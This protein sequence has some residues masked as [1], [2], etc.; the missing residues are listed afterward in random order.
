MDTRRPFSIDELVACSQSTD[1]DPSKSF[2]DLLKIVAAECDAGE[3]ARAANDLEIAFIHFTKASNLVLI[4][5]PTHPEY[6]WRTDRS[7]IVVF[8]QRIHDSLET[9]KPLV[10]ERFSDWRTRHPGADLSTPAPASEVLHQLAA[11]ATRHDLNKW[12]RDLVETATAEHNAGE[13]AKAT[14]DPESACIHFANASTLML[15]ELPTHPKFEELTQDQRA[16]VAMLG[17]RMLNSLGEAK[18]L[19][20]EQYS[21]RRIRRPGA[22]LPASA[23]ASA[24]FQPSRGPTAQQQQQQQPQLSPQDT[25]EGVQL[26]RWARQHQEAPRPVT[27]QEYPEHTLG[28]KQQDDTSAFAYDQVAKIVATRN[29]EKQEQEWQRKDRLEWEEIL[30][31]KNLAQEVAMNDETVTAFPTPASSH[32]RVR[33]EPYETH[34]P[35][36]NQDVSFQLQPHWRPLPRLPLRARRHEV[37]IQP[38][39]SETNLSLPAP[40]NFS[41][42][43]PSWTPASQSLQELQSPRVEP[44]VEHQHG[45]RA[46]YYPFRPS[47]Q[48]E[49]HHMAAPSHINLFGS[50]IKSAPPTPELSASKQ[51]VQPNMFSLVQGQ[52]PH[53]ESGSGLHP[54]EDPSVTTSRVSGAMPI[55]DI[56]ALLVVHQCPDI[57]SRLDLKKCGAT[58]FAGG[59][60]GDVYRGAL[61]GGE[62][63]AIKCARFYLRQDDTKGH[64]VLKHAAREIH[65]WSR[66]KHDNIV[67][68][69]GLAHFR[70]HL[71]MVSPW[72]DNGTLLEY[73]ERNPAADRCRLIAEITDGV[74]YLH[75]N[76]TVTYS[77]LP[78]ARIL[79]YY[80][81]PGTW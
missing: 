47:L 73:L 9:I 55:S 1:Y 71:A 30:A 74:V 34:A 24:L 17:Q 28:Y 72:M 59:G 50:Q 37:Y 69:L 68:L 66:L 62:N 21:D 76:N 79:M 63:V 3:Q 57:T 2:N 6:Y 40:V 44:E 14:D 51:L 8:A 23:P 60:F 80:V 58:A 35:T 18:L 45:S 13:L 42:T 33:P 29:Q 11:R 7:M 25:H 20:G 26:A 27:E 5:L 52:T 19:V 36:S 39:L 81:L 12:I 53:D 65:T 4:D 56:V 64:K 70:D 61:N 10:S 31:G 75:Q 38:S 32:P 22:D 78:T 15:E 49:Q 16:T 48:R 54:L 67:E 46:D 43:S 41:R 77:A